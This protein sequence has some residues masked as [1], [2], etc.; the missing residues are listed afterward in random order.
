MSIIRAGL[1]LLLLPLATMA[2]DH[3]TAECSWLYERIEILETAIRQG[4]ELGTRE[5]L[6]KRKSEFKKKACGQYDY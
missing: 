4:D 6:A 3:P 2:K 1:C 5:E